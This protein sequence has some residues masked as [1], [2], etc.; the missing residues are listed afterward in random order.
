MIGEFL[1]KRVRRFR[2]GAAGAKVL[3]RKKCPEKRALF[4]YKNATYPF[5]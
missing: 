1:G 2:P 5:G 3:Y 4:S